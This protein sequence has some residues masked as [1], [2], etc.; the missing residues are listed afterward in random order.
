MKYLIFGVG[1]FRDL[2]LFGLFYFLYRSWAHDEELINLLQTLIFATLGV[3]SLMAI[4]S[5]RNFYTPIWAMNPFSNKYLVFSV[6][7]SFFLLYAAVEWAPLQKFLSTT[8]LSSA[9]WSMAFLIGLIG[10][11]LNEL[12]KLRFINFSHLKNN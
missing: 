11:G 4:F 8:S 6:L 10:I 2:L 5:L 7:V 9:E 3:K 12:V 1:I